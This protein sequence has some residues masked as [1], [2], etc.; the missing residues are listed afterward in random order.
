[1]DP[2]QSQCPSIPLIYRVI[3]A[4]ISPIDSYPPIAKLVAKAEVVY[5]PILETIAFVPNPALL[6]AA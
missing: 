2:F 6:A 4:F 1:M 3:S 5:L